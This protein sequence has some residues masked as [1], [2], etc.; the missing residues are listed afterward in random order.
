MVRF[1]NVKAGCGRQIIDLFFVI[2]KFKSLKWKVGYLVI[3]AVW[4]TV[5]VA[6]SCVRF[7]YGSFLQSRCRLVTY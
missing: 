4:K 5:R 3:Y 6:L 1:H 2:L 7:D